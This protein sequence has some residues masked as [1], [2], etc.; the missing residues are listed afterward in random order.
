[1]LEC[2]ILGDSIAS[3]IHHVKQGCIGITE[4]G[5]T[6]AE[7]YVKN[8]QRPL[9]TDID[10]R[11]VVISLTTNDLNVRNARENLHLIRKAVRTERVIW[12]LPGDKK[13]EMRSLVE[14]VANFYN[15]HIMDITDHVG[16][17]RIHPPT[18]RA[19]ENI[20]KKIK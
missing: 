13:P 3:G 15:D 18:V 9:I 16:A 8:H 1:M 17:D 4:I 14:D 7:W 12:I 10:Y 20:A 19:Y 2:L 11:Y 6:S 5:I